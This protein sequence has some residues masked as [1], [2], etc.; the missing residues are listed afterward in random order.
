MLS[1]LCMSYCTFRSETQVD[2]ALDQSD[3]G[4]RRSCLNSCQVQGR[5]LVASSILWAWE[6]PLSFPSLVSSLR[7]TF[8]RL[9]SRKNEI[10][11]APCFARCSLSCIR[12]LSSASFCFALS[13]YSSLSHVR[14]KLVSLA[15][16]ALFF[17]DIEKMRVRNQKSWALKHESRGL[18]KRLP[19]LPAQTWQRQ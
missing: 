15:A 5:I 6:G 11:T 1:Y 8:I 19:V 13:A 18:F 9:Y 17:S 16:D 14:L 7:R 2:R 3:C 10:F 4:P 12:S